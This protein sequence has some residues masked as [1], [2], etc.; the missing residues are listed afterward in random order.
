MNLQNAQILIDR[1]RG[2]EHREP[3]AWPKN[4]R[5]FNMSGIRFP[6]GAPSCVAGHC[7]DLMDRRGGS[8]VIADFLDIDELTALAG[9]KR[10]ST[11]TS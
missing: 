3:H 8:D 2:C 6:C 4:N 9:S 5:S 11:S 7:G 10:E 1:L